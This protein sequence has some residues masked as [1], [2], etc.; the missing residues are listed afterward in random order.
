MSRPPVIVDANLAFKALV[1]SRGDL[2]GR[3]SPQV[4]VGLFSPRFLIV[5]LFRHHDRLVHATGLDV[6]S[7]IAALHRLLARLEFVNEALIP[8][9]LWVE[10]HRP[11]RDVDE[12][13]TAHV[14]LTLHL[15][16]RLWTEDKALQEG[17]K[18][19]GFDRF[20]EA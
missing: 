6:E 17:L 16:G 10:A 4:E 3:L 8:L 1:S 12:K 5:E 13:D 7:L 11:R 19:R 2:R 14:A 18:A 9:G 20:F 15:D